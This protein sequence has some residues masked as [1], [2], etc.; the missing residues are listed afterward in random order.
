MDS[1]APLV[2][3]RHLQEWLANV[4][5]EEDPWRARFF[6]AL[7]SRIR[8]EVEGAV[9]TEWLPMAHHVL[10]ADILGH[11]FGPVHA[12][13][14]YRRAF[15]TSL[16]GPVLGPLL[17]TGARVLG[18]NPGSLLRWAGHGWRASFRNAGS[19][20]G[21]VVRENMGRLEYRDMPAVC[22]ASDAWLDSAQGSA[23]GALDAMGATGVVR[24]DKSGRGEGRMTL[25]LEWA[26]EAGGG[27]GGDE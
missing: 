12:H 1:A 5:R 18:L 21:V 24:I 10:F 2:R 20:T 22:I 9:R 14:Y 15:A 4:A 6:E 13:D 3:V 25:E 19:L 27:S 8:D 11:A 23:Y 17:R 7:P 26:G 16:R